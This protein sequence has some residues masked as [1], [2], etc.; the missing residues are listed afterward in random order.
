MHFGSHHDIQMTV[1]LAN[2]AWLSVWQKTEAQGE[3]TQ[4]RFQINVVCLTKLKKL[5]VCF[6]PV[7]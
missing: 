7:Q 1:I 4:T 2:A 6:D 5:L 3:I